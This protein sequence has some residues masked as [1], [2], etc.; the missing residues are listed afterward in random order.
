L[1]S[2]NPADRLA[3]AASRPNI[4]PAGSRGTGGYRK[5]LISCLIL[6]CGIAAVVWAAR[7]E[8]LPVIGT[9]VSHPDNW[10]SFAPADAIVVLSG[11]EGRSEEGLR[12]CQQGLARELW[13]TGAVAGAP[14]T[15]LERNGFGYRALPSS[16]TWEDGLQVRQMV[17]AIGAKRVIVVTSWYHGRRAMRTIEKQ[18]R[19]LNVAVYYQPAGTKGYDSSNWWRHDTGKRLVRAE[20]LKTIYYFFVYGVSPR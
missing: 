2:K 13:E 16:T 17:Q 5:R 7:A 10:S 4:A 19:D 8:W 9:F 11:G 3:D 14:S 18:T 12:L 6:V 15:L 20:L 1:N